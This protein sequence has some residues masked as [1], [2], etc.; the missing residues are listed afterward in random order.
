MSFQSSL[1]EYLQTEFPRANAHVGPLPL[2]FNPDR[3]MQIQW[4]ADV[5]GF[6]V[7]MKAFVAGYDAAHNRLAEQKSTDARDADRYRKLTA[8]LNSTLFFDI[9]TQSYTNQTLAGRK[10]TSDAFDAAVDQLPV[11]R[12][13]GIPK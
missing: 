2:G 12:P 4:D 3:D 8:L 13:E 1:L 9:G 7:A 10:L 11:N 6:R 5:T